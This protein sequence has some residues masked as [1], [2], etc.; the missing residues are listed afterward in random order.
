MITKGYSDINE[1]MSRKQM[2]DQIYK[3]HDGTKHAEADEEE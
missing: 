3:L 1:S 2:L